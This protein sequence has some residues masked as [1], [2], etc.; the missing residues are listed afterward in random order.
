MDTSKYKALYLQEADEHLSGIEKGL[1][2]L[3]K[4]EDNPSPVENLFRHYHSI[5]GMSA[6]MGYE[7]ISRLSHAQEDLLDRV[8]SKR[9]KL[10]SAMLT[11]LFKCTDALKELIKRVEEDKPLTYD[12]DPLIGEIK[13]LIEGRAPA[14]QNVPAPAAELKLSQTM[15]VDVKIFDGLL[16][17]AGDLFMTLSSFKTLTQGNRSIAVKDSLHTL[18]RSINALYDNI[19]SARM[20][21]IKDLTEGLPRVVR[22]ISSDTGKT[23]DLKVE[24]A[25]ISVDR[26]ILE[27]LASPLVHMIRNAVDHGIEPPGKR[28]EANKPSVGTITINAYIK[29]NRV[30]IEVSD[31]G[32]GIDR[33]K[34]IARAIGMGVPAERIRAMSDEDVLM[35]VCTPG[36]SVKEEVTEISGRGVGMDVVKSAVEAFG[37]G[38]R[39]ESEKGLGTKVI[40]ELPRTSSIVKALLVTAGNEL[41][42]LPASRIEQVLE[43]K[44]AELAGG[45]FKYG[46][47]DIPLISLDKALGIKEN[48]AKDVYTI[49]I[50]E[51]G[52]KAE[53]AVNIENS[54]A[55]KVDDFKDEIDAY[56]KPLLPPISKLWGVSGITVMADGRPVFLLDV[57]QI[58]SRALKRVSL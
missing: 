51:D 3:E 11:A 34:V 15:K 37:G 48:S 38:L 56:I 1:L 58:I 17:T 18:G 30:I 44:N 24:G 53:S 32:G 23:V 14:P 12:V 6:S 49:V 7:N 5:K 25:E 50:V 16:A 39:I 20:L 57:R 28:A 41:F 47:R 2:G 40:M 31:D 21:P 36:L 42:L 52:V 19:I 27:N 4:G 33:E 35:L 54:A 9:L 26:A 13:G 10:S 22:D 46:G 55:I 43:A 45:T 8:R 29:K